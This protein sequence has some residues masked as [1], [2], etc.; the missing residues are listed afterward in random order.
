[1]KNKKIEEINK[2]LEQDIKDIQD[3]NK[4]NDLKVKYLGKK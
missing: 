3:R 4:L 1:M 2:M